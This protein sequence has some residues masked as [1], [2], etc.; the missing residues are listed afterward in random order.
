MQKYALGLRNIIP[1]DLEVVVCPS[2][3]YLPYFDGKYDFKLGAQSV[4]LS[5]VISTGEVSSKQLR[6]FNVNYAILGHAEKNEYDLVNEKVKDCL[7]EGINPILCI[8]ESREERLL[9]KTPLV[10]TKQLKQYLKDVDDVTNFVIVYEPKWLIGSNRAMALDDIINTV[11]M[12][13]EIVK[14]LYGAEVKVLYGGGV[15]L[16]NIVR[17][18][19]NSN[20]DGVMIGKVSA[21]IS[22][23]HKIFVG[24]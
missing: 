23:V 14:D 22:F 9:N 6:S 5:S 8:G 3:I 4:S 2:L 10:L 13:R 20:I 21:D 16:N 18:A 15:N 7:K 19:N 12:I 1:N 17:I 24:D 11:K